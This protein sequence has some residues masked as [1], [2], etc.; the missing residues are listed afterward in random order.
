MAL[1]NV[2]LFDKSVQTANVWIKE[3]AEDL[4]WSDEHKVYLALKG[5]LHALRDRLPPEA[6]VHL[7]AQLP[8]IISGVYYDSWKPSRSPL[9]YKHKED[10]IEHMRQPF[11]P[12]AQ[13][14]DF[15]RV[16]QAVFRLLAHKV[17]EGEIRN[18][19]DDLPKELSAWWAE[20][21]GL[22]HH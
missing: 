21:T 3:L 10:F 22:V 20:A 19:M 5:T 16:A 7:G 18:I 13:V 12:Q 4:G 15:D 17:T 1:D 8:L 9:K 11:R 2:H 6:A 14:D